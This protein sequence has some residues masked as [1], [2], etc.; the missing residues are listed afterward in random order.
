VKQQPKPKL[1]GLRITLDAGH[2]G[3]MNGAMGTTGLKEKDINLELVMLLK[4]ELEK[5]GVEVLLTRADDSNV[6]MEQ[7]FEYLNQYKPDILISIHNNAS[8][9]PIVQG[10]S[11]YYRHIGFRPLS[12]A[13]LN[14][15]LELGVE[16]AGN[17]GS[18]DFAL[19]ALTECP[20]VLIEGLF[21]SNPQDEAKLLDKRFRNRFVKKI[22]NGIE[23][24]LFVQSKK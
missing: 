5:R 12:M 24:F 4:K 23:D 6:T 11:T 14:R 13:I 22:V 7:R 2:G 3:E 19:N 9:N 15:L 8:G 16:N 20:N 10:T 1:K 21:L 17:I 18:F